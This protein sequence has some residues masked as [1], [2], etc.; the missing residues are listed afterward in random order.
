MISDF[1]GSC[2]I[3]FIKKACCSIETVGFN[4]LISVNIKNGSLRFDLHRFFLL[5]FIRQ[6]AE[7]IVPDWG[8]NTEKDVL[9]AVVVDG[10]VGP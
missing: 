7:N 6:S 9:V 3:K 4:L 2:F 1:T 10:V 8:R 5:V